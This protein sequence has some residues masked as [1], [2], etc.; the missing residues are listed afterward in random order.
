AIEVFI[1]NEEAVM[2][3]EPHLLEH[4]LHPKFDV[5]ALASKRALGSA[6]GASPGASSGRIYFDVESRLAA[7]A[8]GEDKTILVR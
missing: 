2:L 8:R 6:L 3:V 7:K 4:L 1:T 5:K